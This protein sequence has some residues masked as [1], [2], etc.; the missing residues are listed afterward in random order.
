MF[1]QFTFS[2]KIIRL[3]TYTISSLEIHLIAPTTLLPCFTFYFMIKPIA[4]IFINNNISHCKMIKSSLIKADN[5]FLIILCLFPITAALLKHNAVLLHFIIVLS[6]CCVLVYRDSFIST[7]RNFF[8]Y[9]FSNLF[10]LLLISFIIYITYNFLFISPYKS[11]TFKM[12]FLPFNI[13][14]LFGFL[15]L[16]ISQH[17]RFNNKLIMYSL[18]SS[19]ALYLALCVI[20]IIKN[21]NEVPLILRLMMPFFFLVISCLSIMELYKLNYAFKVQ[22]IAKVLFLIINALLV[23]FSQDNTSKLVFGISLIIIII[24]YFARN[25]HFLIMSTGVI[26]AATLPI[27]IANI[28]DF[29][30]FNTNAFNK[31]LRS[32]QTR[33]PQWINVLDNFGQKPITGHGVYASYYMAKKPDFE[34]ELVTLNDIIQDELQ[35]N[36]IA[37]ENLQKAHYLENEYAKLLTNSFLIKR[38]NHYYQLKQNISIPEYGDKFI[39]AIK[40]QLET[41]DLML[42]ILVE[43]KQIQLNPVLKKRLDKRIEYLKE[44]HLQMEQFLKYYNEASTYDAKHIILKKELEKFLSYPQ[45]QIVT[46]PHNIILHVLFELGIIGI[47]FLLSIIF[48]ILYK[49]SKVEDLIYRTIGYILYFIFLIIYS[50]AS[51]IWYMGFHQIMYIIAFIFIVISTQKTSQKPNLN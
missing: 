24:C 15:L 41:I 30:I 2:N 34:E 10:F 42:E 11:P 16:Y 40:E 19:V 46:H 21:H 50:T 47:L 18:M 44:E 49:I 37:E 3:I 51:S 27:A 28:T 45:F 31:Q 6:W 36:I 39:I 14:S 26:L 32:I 8:Q 43:L 33:V 4:N 48:Y 38:T 12:Q 13:T 5:I 17:V 25:R 35:I 1:W 7:I 22:T 29:S 9:I 23:F 20:F